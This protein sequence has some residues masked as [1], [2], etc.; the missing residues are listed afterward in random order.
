MREHVV[1]QF[2]SIG[3]PETCAHNIEKS[4]YNF[5]IAYANKNHIDKSWTDARFKTLYMTKYVQMFT[6]FRGNP[7]LIQEVIDNKTSK[8]VGLWD[9][10]DFHKDN[11]PKTDSESTDVQG[12][13]EGLFKC[14]KCGSKKT[15][16]YSMQTRSADE[17]M[18]NFI[19]CVSCKHRWKN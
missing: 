1:C 11:E 5:C 14:G 2:I 17:P 8:F 15:T 10:Q 19:T 3:F 7:T 4:L 13:E 12:I 9:V 16:Y 6:D 18:T